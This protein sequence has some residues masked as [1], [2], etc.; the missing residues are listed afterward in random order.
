MGLF[1]KNKKDFAEEEIL[2]EQENLFDSIK[3]KDQ[4][5][6]KPNVL[7]RDE[8]IGEESNDSTPVYSANPLNEIRKKMLSRQ[9]Q[10]NQSNT[11][12]IK[13]EF[14][15]FFNIDTSFLDKVGETVKDERK[16]SLKKGEKINLIADIIDDTVSKEEK[17]TQDESILESCL[18]FILD[19]REDET[20]PEEKPAYTL[21]SVASILGIDEEETVNEEPEED[22]EAE[23]FEETIVFSTITKEKIPDISDI[24]TNEK[25]VSL[26][27]GDFT[28]TMSVFIN[29]DLIGNTRDVDIS[30]ELLEKEKAQ[31]LKEKDLPLIDDSFEPE[32]EY[33]STDDRK[34]IRF[35]IL[36]LRKS[37]FLKF[38]VSSL[39]LIVL[40]VFLLPS[41]SELKEEFSI[42]LTVFTCLA[43]LICV[44]TN[45][46]IFKSFLTLNGERCSADT[47]LAAAVIFAVTGI[48]ITII[49]STASDIAYG[50]GFMTVLSL[51]FR[52][53]WLFKKYQYMYV[54]FTIAAANNDKYALSL[55]NDA[56]TTFAM[57]R[58]AIDG[59]VLIAAQR[60]SRNITDFMKNSTINV[61]LDGKGKLIFIVSLVFSLIAATLLG[62]YKDNFTSAVTSCVGFSFLFAPITALACFTKPMSDA[63]R[64]TSRYG[65]ALTG[66]N[67]A[68]QIEQANACVI[69]CGDLFPA[70]S[71]QLTDMKVLNEN[72]LEETISIACAITTGINSPLASV[73]KKIT[74][75][76]S[77]IKI[78]VADSIK[79]EE[80]LG[81]TGWVGDKRIF[82]GNRS[83]MIAHEI[84]TPDSSLDIKILSEGC[85]PVYLAC[86]GKALAL[87][88]LRYVPD[89]VIAKELD[90][91]T[92]MGLTLLINNCDQNISEE[93]LCD[94]FDLYSDS[95]KIMSGSGVHMYK[96]ATNYSESLSAGAFMKKSASAIA[97]V[98]FASNK[99]T[100]AVSL[101]TIVHY[102]T[103]VLGIII[104]AYAFFGSATSLISAV[105][106]ALYQ[107]ICYALGGI[108]YLFTKP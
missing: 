35:K 40:S 52:S 107:L 75:T 24:D 104:F 91:I 80:K 42:L 84:D 87:I 25:G 13:E 60:R 94:Y 8:I 88:T 43:T 90:R 92:A 66:V 96:T 2:F 38:I 97:S 21:E 19:G 27:N 71:I 79:Y 18:P 44:I 50:F 11:E 83:L 20:L 68:R 101:L 54:N 31:S 32:D 85:F 95:V 98:V 86:D 6:P 74:Q 108:A 82:I 33:I 49:N 103:V 12:E 34:R 56:P 69:D 59:D 36:S 76:N 47:P 48:M 28:G 10:N 57:A 37:Y 55:I 14:T 39:C 7:T 81:I 41:F 51:A 102:I 46:D 9:E 72:N 64:H 99:V 3:I 61:D 105:Y 78:P 67:A 65:A 45:I 4:N 30:G 89:K 5:A 106:I 58:R 22:I 23:S 29:D 63:V 62:F 26:E 100:K 17:I 16:N 77:D 53:F 15:P 73:F 70:G 1:K 93:M